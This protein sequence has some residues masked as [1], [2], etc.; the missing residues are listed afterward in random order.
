M[1]FARGCVTAFYQA[2]VDPS[3]TH[4]LRDILCVAYSRHLMRSG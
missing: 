1:S 4:G 2:D 3:Y